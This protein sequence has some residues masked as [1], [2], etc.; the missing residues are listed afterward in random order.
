ML[1]ERGR[2]SPRQRKVLD[3]AAERPLQVQLGKMRSSVSSV[4]RR[5]R[6]TVTMRVNTVP[7]T[8]ATILVEAADAG[9]RQS[10]WEYDRSPDVPPGQACAGELPGPRSACCYSAGVTNCERMT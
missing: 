7:D 3:L 8:H 9:K 6:M 1:Q 4:G 2:Q 10:A 5:G